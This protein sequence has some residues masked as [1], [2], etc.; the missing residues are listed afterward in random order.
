MKRNVAQAACI[1]LPF[2]TALVGGIITPGYP[3]AGHATTLAMATIVAFGAL[4]A[5][6][7][8]MRNTPDD[9][10][11][12]P[13]AA[14]WL[15]AVSI[16]IVTMMET[17]I[18]KPRGIDN[19]QWLP[20]MALAAIAI[21]ALCERDG[22]RADRDAFQRA[23]SLAMLCLGG[24]LGVSLMIAAAAGRMSGNDL[25]TVGITILFAAPVFGAAVQTQRAYHGD[26]ARLGMGVLLM[27]FMAIV[28]SEGTYT[29][30][31]HYNDD[32]AARTVFQ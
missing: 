27:L 28:T 29:W 12:W 21:L 14:G 19:R 7:L 20:C 9:D 17:V 13:V 5:L 22:R 4:F 30:T 25:A 32:A 1:A 31:P 2:V 24:V 6:T 10:A 18:L 8:N 15:L 11:G 3:V 23:A 16:F 26:R